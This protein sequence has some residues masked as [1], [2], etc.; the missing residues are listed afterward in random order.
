MKV[1]TCA[2]MVVAV[3]AA[4]QPAYA[5]D[6]QSGWF[7]RVRDELGETWTLGTTEYFA[8]FRTWHAPWAYTQDQNK[9]YQ[10]W[11]PGFGLGRGRFDNRGNWHGVYAMGF[12]DSHFKPEWIAGYGWKT[13]WQAPGDIRLG[14]GYTA[15]ITA[16]TDIGHYTP[17][18]LL[19]PIVSVDYGKLSVESAYV[20]GGKG[21]GNVFLIWAKLHSDNKSL[22]GWTL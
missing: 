13:Y 19:L 9:H 7:D 16:R 6:Q 21:N 3:L 20:P 8:T 1:A 2:L 18:P 4:G 17:V 11:P 14:L 15:G 5:D 22:F 12:Q 10:N